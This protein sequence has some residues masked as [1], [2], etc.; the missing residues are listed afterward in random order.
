MVRV[1]PIYRS[2]AP[3]GHSD[4]FSSTMKVQVAEL[5]APSNVIQSPEM[6]FTCHSIQDSHPYGIFYG[7]NPLNSSF[8]LFLLDISLVIVIIQILR[9]LLKP[10]KQPRIVAEIILSFFFFFLGLIKLEV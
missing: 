9:F 3:S 1:Y 2:L 5:H 4:G 7:E 6:I 8:T 10:L